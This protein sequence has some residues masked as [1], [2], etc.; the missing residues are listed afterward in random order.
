MVAQAEAKLASVEA[1]M[2]GATE[3]GGA[4]DAAL[5][6]VFLHNMC[7]HGRLHI[8]GTQ[9]VHDCGMHASMYVHAN[10]GPM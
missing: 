3:W 4:G 7:V 5:H 10:P 8:G 1:A 6:G 2:Q 9:R